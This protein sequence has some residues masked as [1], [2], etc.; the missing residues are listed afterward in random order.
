MI[1]KNPPNDLH[2]FGIRH[3]GPGSARS[4]RESLQALQPDIV[5]VEGPPDANHLLPWLVHPELTP[6]VALIIYRPDQP[7]RATYYPFAVFS[8][9]LQAVRY[10]LQQ[11]VPVRFMDLPL[12]HQLAVEIK[13][14]LPD[15]DPLRQLAKVAGYK[16]YETWWNLL[17]EHRRNGADLFAGILT[18]M[19]AVRE[20]ADQRVPQNEAEQA[21]RLFNDRREAYMRRCIRQA[22]E[23][24]FQRVA[25]VC[26]AWHAP[27]LIDLSPTVA[28]T[29]LLEALPE[30]DVEAAWVPW[31]YSRLSYFT[32]YGAGISSPG[33]YHHLWEMGQAGVSQIELCV[34]WL[35][36][37][38][39]LLREE[40]IDTSSAH[41]IEAVRLAEALAA[42]RELPFPGLAE[43][44]EATQTVICFGDAAPIRLI[45]EALIISERMGAVPPN[46]PMVPLQRDLY[47]LQQQLRLR[48]EPTKSTLTLDLRNTMHLERSHLLHRLRLLK[49]PWGKI[50][51]LRGKQGTYREVW[52]LHWLPDFAIRVIEA[53]VW[54]NTIQEAATQ[55]AKHE[56]DQASTLPAL[57]HLLDQ[58]ILAELPDTI[59]YL[60]SRIEEEAAL[61]SDIPHMMEALP[62]LAQV[63]RYGNVRNTDKGMIYHVVDGL[64]TRI[65]VGLPTTCASMDDK[66]AAEMF[67]HITAVHGVV[68][69]LENKD[70]QQLWQQVLTKL[71]DH[72]NL[73]GLIAGRACRLL[74]DSAFFKP[75]DAAKR[76]KQ[77]LPTHNLAIKPTGQLLQAAFWLE[78]FLKGSGLL[79]LHDQTLWQILDQWVA[80]L[81]P[82]QFLHILPLLRRTF[83]TFEPTI[84]QQMRERIRF[85]QVQRQ[86]DPLVYDEFDFTQADAVLP[87][88][89]RLLG[90]E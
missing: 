87:L 53:S 68:V 86:Q 78:G 6:P 1:I 61:S 69:T 15:A 27:A 74:L 50:M 30:V 16:S 2:I 7:K 18:M 66:A 88:V 41:I 51:P 19:Q 29:A 4:L 3:H 65:C 56:A 49:I 46:T 9:E 14:K 81:T 60:M 76:L 45:Q 11:E 5:L 83:V 33:W 22:K 47:R 44:N 71:A 40:K 80:Q 34:N 13:A 23:E 28:D 84:R 39:N 70:H 42:I 90:V 72:K 82:E 73:H 54:G 17:V 8:P 26:G 24:G 89:A 67:D 55:F 25:I 59:T 64:L 62:P 48:P 43:L 35:V 31:T 79:L 38:A 52:Q 10:A 37:I 12:T 85:G 21:G 57:T 36:K 63:L 32:G 58:I 75:E 77:A 20:E